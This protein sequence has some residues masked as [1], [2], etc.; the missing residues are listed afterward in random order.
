VKQLDSNAAKLAVRWSKEP[1]FQLP[2]DTETLRNLEILASK[3]QIQKLYSEC[4]WKACEDFDQLIEL[5][6]KFLKGEID[7]TPYHVGPIE[8]ETELLVQ[9]L[10]QLHDY[11]LLTFNGQPFE[12]QE[13]F[14]N[15]DSQSW[16]DYQQRPYLSF[17]M[18]GQTGNDAAY[19]TLFKLLKSTT[20]VVVRATKVCSSEAVHESDHEVVVTR[21]R[22]SQTTENLKSQ[23]WRSLTSCLVDT[24]STGEDLFL[25]RAMQNSDPVIFD[26]AAKEWNDPV[27]LIGVVAELAKK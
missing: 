23:P 10:L 24:D 13:S 7:S 26:V 8:T 4:L 11:R 3:L 14:W 6:R 2:G 5:N 1:C 25:L 22:L 16:A 15:E 27:N 12:N 17:I 18:E 21:E 20:N 19:L 9:D